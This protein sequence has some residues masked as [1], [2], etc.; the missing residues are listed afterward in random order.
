[1]WGRSSD[2]C[3]ARGCAGPVDFAMAPAW[4]LAGGTQD[5]DRPVGTHWRPTVAAAMPEGPSAA[6]HFPLAAQHSRRGGEDQALV[7]WPAAMARHS[8]PRSRVASLLSLIIAAQ[9]TP[10]ANA[11][12][13]ISS[14]LE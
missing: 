4:V 13:Q 11:T 3:A 1:M 9:H 14:T 6:D 5:Q 12:P 7:P 8:S 2:R 10:Y